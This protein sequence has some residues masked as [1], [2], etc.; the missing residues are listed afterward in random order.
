MWRL[1][2]GEGGGDPYTYSTNNYLGRQTWEFDPNAGTSEERA[3]VEEVLLNYYSNRKHVQ[4]SSDL[5]W[6]IQSCGGGSFNVVA[7]VALLSCAKLHLSSIVQH[8][9]HLNM[10]RT[11]QS[12]KHESFSL[13]S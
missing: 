13:V 10:I 5:L 3:E 2:I 11:G 12:D 4:P 6:W 1:K 7:S 9:F 8:N